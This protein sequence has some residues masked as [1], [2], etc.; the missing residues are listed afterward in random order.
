MY[1]GYFNPDASEIIEVED[2]QL[3][4]GP[5]KF[6]PFTNK[7]R[8]TI[9]SAL[10]K[11]KDSGP[12]SGPQMSLTGH[13]PAHWL[14]LPDWSNLLRKFN[15][16]ILL[17]PDHSDFTKSRD[18]H[19]IVTAG[20]AAH[21]RG[22]FTVAELTANLPANI[23]HKM[24]IDPGDGTPVCIFLDYLDLLF[25]DSFTIH[26]NGEDIW[27]SDSDLTP[28]IRL[29]KTTIIKL[30]DPTAENIEKV[31]KRLLRP[32][33]DLAGFEAWQAMAR[34]GTHPLNFL[35][36]PRQLGPMPRHHVG[37]GKHFPRGG[38]PLDGGS[39]GRCR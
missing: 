35:P 4:L 28:P 6:D 11:F 14:R 34:I 5:S 7:T 24:T 31:S 29:S 33:Q 17:L 26:H 1:V 39:C 9:T 27:K 21:Q 19:R 30:N 13:N 2:L 23:V 37:P 22:E 3:S 16:N 25:D 32:P 36:M 15:A 18:V 20:D 38:R 10:S 8:L 12:S